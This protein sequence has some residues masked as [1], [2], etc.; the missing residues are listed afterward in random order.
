ME[1]NIHYLT[2]LLQSISC[3]CVGR[4]MQVSVQLLVNCAVAVQL[5][6]LCSIMAFHEKVSSPLHYNENKKNQLEE[7]DKTVKILTRDLH[8]NSPYIKTPKLAVQPLVPASVLHYLDKIND[9]E[10]ELSS[11]QQS[12][13]NFKSLYSQLKLQYNEL[14]IN[15]THQQKALNRDLESLQDQ[16]DVKLINNRKAKATMEQNLNFKALEMQLRNSINSLEVENKRLLA[17]AQSAIQLETENANLHQLLQESNEN[18]LSTKRASVQLLEE[19]LN[20]ASK[21]IFELE[22]KLDESA[23]LHAAQREKLQNRLK[24]KENSLMQE[25]ILR[26]RSIKQFVQDSKTAE[27]DKDKEITRLKREILLRTEELGRVTQH[28]VETALNNGRTEEL[29]KEN[30][31]LH[32]LLTISN[33]NLLKSTQ[34]EAELNEIINSL[35]LQVNRL[36]LS[37][38]TMKNHLNSVNQETV[39]KFNL[40]LQLQQNFEEFQL[41]FAAKEIETQR[42]KNTEEEMINKESCS[43]DRIQVLERSNQVL[44]QR[45]KEQMKLVEYLYRVIQNAV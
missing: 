33:T 9:L 1:N 10:S 7:L 31:E 34:K 26:E 41:N 17:A 42:I 45:L 20:K 3:C 37:E 29:D 43:A 21:T 18:F 44:E 6:A 24:Q 38:V 32:Q 13:S 27:I 22:S 36:Q 8:D 40:Y 4:W 25:D 14:E 12:N 11:L 19:K 2:T 15:S 35:N 16:L 30:K 5:F 23:R 28:N 39:D